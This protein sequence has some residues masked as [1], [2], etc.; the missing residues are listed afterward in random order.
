MPKSRLAILL[1][2]LVVTISVPVGAGW[3]YASVAKQSN[4]I[5]GTTRLKDLD[6]LL[7]QSSFFPSFGDNAKVTTITQRYPVDPRQLGMKKAKGT[8]M[9]EYTCLGVQGGGSR[10]LGRGKDKFDAFGN[11]ATTRLV[12]ASRN[13]DFFRAET[14]F[15]GSQKQAAGSS[16]HVL[17]GVQRLP[18]D[19]DSDCYDIDT[20]C[21]LDGRFKAEVD[22]RSDGSDGFATP[23]A[24]GFDDGLFFFFNETNTLMTIN[25]LDACNLQGFNNFW[26]FAAATTNIEYT[27]TVTDTQSGQSRSYF[28][29][30]GQPA[31]AI[32]DT[33][34]FAT[35]P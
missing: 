6:S 10:N 31:E 29:P 7:F 35:C 11:A 32:T 20:L 4:Y 17:N 8:V 33:S 21:L 24:T 3:N 12:P 13:C 22:W 26:V 23:I 25:I 18:P 34:A 15:K 5:H 16:V 27:L 1:F 28:N 14:S 9:N 19:V 30:L 2:L